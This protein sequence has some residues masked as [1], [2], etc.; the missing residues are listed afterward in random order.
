MPR[1]PIHD[2]KTLFTRIAEGDEP[3][4]RTVFDFYK[5][6]FHSAAF[7][8]TRSAT[9]AEE[10]VQEVF[11]SLWNNRRHIADARNPES[12]L[13]KILHNSIYAHFRKLVLDKQLKKNIA[14]ENIQVDE[15]PVEQLLLAK[16]NREFLDTVISRLPPQQQLVYRLSK[17]EGLS[18]EEIA[19]KLNIS[20]NTV[21]NH[22]SA[23]V[24][25]IVAYFKKGASV[26]V[27]AVISQSL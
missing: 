16:E 10:I 26:L 27:W 23:A 3:S 25:F 7:R 14:A 22:L 24:E 5:E 8:M 12:Y 15:N 20:P 9:I 21:R 19:V 1:H 11:I 2:I 17:Q 13:V 6:P 18:R 4:F